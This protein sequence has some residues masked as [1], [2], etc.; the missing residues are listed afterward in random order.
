MYVSDYGYAASPDAWTTNLGSY[1]NSTI[2]NRKQLVIYGAI[3]M[4]NY[5]AFAE[6][7]Q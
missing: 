2:F 5:S 1:D 4:D 7:E 3:G 6:V